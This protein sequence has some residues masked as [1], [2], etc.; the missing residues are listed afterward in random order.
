MYRKVQ[1]EN[2][3]DIPG[4]PWCFYMTAKGELISAG[5]GNKVLNWKEEVKKKPAKK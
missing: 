2:A 1:L 5:A 3:P 4:I